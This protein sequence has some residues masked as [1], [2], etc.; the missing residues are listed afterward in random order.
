MEP[1]PELSNA[2]A[3]LAD[4][5]RV[6][7]IYAREAQGLTLNVS[8]ASGPLEVLWYSPTKAS[9][10]Q[11]AQLAGGGVRKLGTPP[12]SGDIAA[13]IRRAK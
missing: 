8:D 11:G 3:T 2:D 13:I 1:H 4:P 10:Q 6:Y 5:G 9:W 7:A 12:F